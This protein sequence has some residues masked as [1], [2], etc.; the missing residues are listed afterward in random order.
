VFS[1]SEDHWFAV[2]GDVQGKGAGAAA[3]TALA[4]YTIRAAAVRRRSPA[5]ILRWLSDVMLRQQGSDSRF[6]TIACVHV[7]C[8]RA[9]LR[10]T[11][12]CGGHPLP[13][14]LR[15][16][17]GVAEIGAAGTL[18]GLIPQPDLQDRSTD[19]HPGDALLLYTDGLTEARAPADVWAP[20]QLAA[21]LHEARGRP[22]QEIVDHLASAAMPE[23]SEDLRDDVAVVALRAR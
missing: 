23:A 22:A 1:V 15:A 12:A 3:I 19:L 18:L 20:E 13:L 17:G 7:D 6:C 9:P 11:V 4:R 14:V 2:I 21:A 5:A 10:F 8:S 16:A